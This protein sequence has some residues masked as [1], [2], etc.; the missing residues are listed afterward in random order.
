MTSPIIDPA[1]V[2]NLALAEIGFKARIGSLYDGT[3]AAKKILDCYAEERD[4]LLDEGDWDFAERTT[5]GVLLKQAP[6]SYLTT[7]WTPSYPAVP[8][9]FEY[10]FPPDAVGVRGVK[11]QQ[12]TIPNFDPRYNRFEVVNDAGPQT[13]AGYTPPL[14]VVLCNVANAIVV[15]TGQVTNPDEWTP[16]FL[17]ALVSRIAK[18]IGPALMG[19]EIIK[20]AAPESQADSAMAARIRG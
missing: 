20:V 10:A 4:A 15:Y 16:P 18:S 13:V 3:L 5:V 1:S 6:A 11:T 19:P 17:K 8:W 14:K 7:P 2:G 9:L 12:V